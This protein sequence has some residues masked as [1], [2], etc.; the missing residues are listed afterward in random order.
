MASEWPD[1][2]KEFRKEEERQRKRKKCQANSDKS[3]DEIEYTAKKR[4]LSEFS[5]IAWDLVC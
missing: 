5:T 4:K 3:D 2:E 1:Y